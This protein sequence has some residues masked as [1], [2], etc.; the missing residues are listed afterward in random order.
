MSTPSLTHDY[1]SSPSKTSSY[2]GTVHPTTTLTNPYEDLAGAIQHEMAQRRN[3]QYKRP[4]ILKRQSHV[5]S[6]GGSALSDMINPARK[7]LFADPDVEA[8]EIVEIIGTSTGTK[9]NRE[10]LPFNRL[11]HRRVSGGDIEM[12]DGGS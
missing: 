2:S 12:R 5:N 4:G 7:A 6:E 1:S 3:S 9:A 8:G 11:E 10:E